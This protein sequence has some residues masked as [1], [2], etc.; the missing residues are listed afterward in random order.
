VT[1]R[2]RRRLVLAAVLVGVAWVLA[3]WAARF[4]IDEWHFARESLAAFGSL[5][6]ATPNRLVLALTVVGGLAAWWLAYRLRRVPRLWLSALAQWMAAVG[7]CIIGLVT[8]EPFTVFYVPHHDIF[9]RVSMYWQT[10]QMLNGGPLLLI[11]VALCLPK[12]G[13]IMRGHPK[14]KPTAELVGDRVPEDAESRSDIWDG[15][16]PSV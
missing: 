2:D 7:V 9:A 5:H 11:G 4:A 13:L 6:V 14:T 8:T 16:G 1:N 10:L 15:W 3:I 12:P